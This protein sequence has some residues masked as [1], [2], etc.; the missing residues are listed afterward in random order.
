MADLINSG[1][2]KDK[3]TKRVTDL[4]NW[5]NEKKQA[6]L[7][8][9]E[10]VT[11]TPQQDGTVEISA[12]GGAVALDDLT[13][14]DVS[15]VTD[16]QALVYDETNEKWIAGESGKVDDVLMN[17]NSIVQDKI[18]S[19]NNYVELTQAEYDAL[20][21]SKYSDGIL[22]C[23]K[24]SGIDAHDRFCPII[25][26]YNEREIGVWTDGKPLYQ[27]T[28]HINA[29]PSTPNEE[30]YY[31]HGIAN[32]DSVISHES[33]FLW[34][35]SQNKQVHMYDRLALFQQ[36]NGTHDIENAFR[37]I[38]GNFGGSFSIEADRTRFIIT[39]GLDRSALSAD[40]TIRYTKT[41][42]LAGSGTWGTDGIPMHH[43]SKSE[44]IVGT[45]LD[46]RTLY[47]KTIIHGVTNNVSEPLIVL[48]STIKNT[49]NSYVVYIEGI[50]GIGQLN[51]NPNG[52]TLDG[53][54]Y[55]ITPNHFYYTYQNP[56]MTSDNVPPVIYADKNGINW[57]KLETEDANMCIVT[58][59]Y[60]KI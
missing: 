23:I 12:G 59:R 52:Y 20:P 49:V 48:D 40:I 42:D 22:Y 18:V 2:K 11:L 25:Y 10:N 38:N 47:E 4:L 44:H 9:G 21:D 19:F 36:D 17:G 50:V 51:N 41:T 34:T 31:P 35:Q 29:L 14:V 60:V 53:S 8:E 15:S 46:G 39:V 57:R 3:W 43:Y 54:I 32:I 13:D 24:D 58:V 33:R 55:P 5:L 30:T 16:G 37:I 6:K 27:K 7:V 45:W 28:V 26:S 1:N 56:S